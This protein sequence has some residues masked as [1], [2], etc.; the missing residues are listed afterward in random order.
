M[1]NTDIS[2][3]DFHSC[4]SLQVKDRILLLQLLELMLKL[5]LELKLLLGLPL[6][7][8]C[9]CVCARALLDISM[10]KTLLLSTAQRAGDVNQGSGL[11]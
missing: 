2:W 11:F 7:L 3:L 6:K 9:V 10:N 1:F 4:L 8:L 5:L